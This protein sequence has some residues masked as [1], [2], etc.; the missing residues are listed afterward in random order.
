MFDTGCDDR[1]P[2]AVRPA[3]VG[4]HQ[5]RHILPATASVDPRGT[6]RLGSDEPAV[7]AGAALVIFFPHDKIFDKSDLIKLC[8]SCPVFEKYWRFNF[9]SKECVEYNQLKYC[10]FY[11]SRYTY[12]FT[13]DFILR[14]FG[15]SFLLIL[16][17]RPIC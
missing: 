14:Y 3:P 16:Y 15:L 1:T 7:V 13:K 11:L 2:G 6:R 8:I 10:S 17:D 9:W 4:G 5:R 12:N